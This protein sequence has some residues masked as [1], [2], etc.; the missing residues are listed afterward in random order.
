MKELKNEPKLKR[1]YVRY[2]TREV[3]ISLNESSPN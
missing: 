1:K 2:S 3:A